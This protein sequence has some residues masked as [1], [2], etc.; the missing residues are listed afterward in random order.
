MNMQVR[1]NTILITGGS[2]GIGFAL[3]E[4]FVKLGNRVIICGRR[5]DRLEDAKR[6]LPALS[7][8]QCDVSKEYDRKNMYA[9]IE[10]NFKELNVLVNN[11]GIQRRVDFTKGTDDL[12]KNEDEIEINLKAQIYLAAQFVPML[13]KQKDAAIVNV[14]SGLGFV[15]LT[16]FP[17]Y[18]ATKAAI[19]S[20]TM[21]LRYQ[22]RGTS[23]KVFEVIPPTVYDTELKGEPIENAAWTVSSSEVAEAVV[24]GL[25][26]D[27]FE[28]A[29]GPSKKWISSTRNELDLTFG[30][31]NH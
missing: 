13:S 26:E 3:A 23:V 1:K 6:R 15:P 31:I 28:I 2:T 29:M 21:S 14:S 4:S 16:I 8:K 10:E 17:I 5:A 30:N 20:F 24:K 19:H 18:S 7:V 11:A 25:E 27:E 12:L 22:L 9:W